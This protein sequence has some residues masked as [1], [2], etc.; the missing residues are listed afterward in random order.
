MLQKICHVC[1]ENIIHD[2]KYTINTVYSCQNHCID[3]NHYIEYH[4]I[5]ELND[6]RIIIHKFFKNDM[7]LSIDII[8]ERCS[9]WLGFTNTQNNHI[10]LDRNLI[11]KSYEELIELYEKLILL[12]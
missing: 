6:N 2:P 5:N 1:G 3:Q 11:D 4:F 12:K 9:S 7:F 10:K 8:N